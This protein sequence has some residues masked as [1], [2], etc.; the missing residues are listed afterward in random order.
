MH[1]AVSF[2]IGL[3]L[4]LANWIFWQRW[5]KALLQKEKK[6]REAAIIAFSLVKLGVVAGVIWLL[7]FQFGLQP[8][9]F[10]AGLTLAVIGM[11]LRGL[12]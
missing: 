4:G 9:G 11:L 7:L 1:F 10:L 3:L 2:A 12:L 8:V 5:G 6:G